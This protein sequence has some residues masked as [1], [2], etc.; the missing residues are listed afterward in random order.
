MTKADISRKLLKL[1]DLLETATDLSSIWA[2]FDRHLGLNE[3]FIDQCK[4]VQDKEMNLIYQAI[5]KEVFQGKTEWMT[6]TPMSFRYKEQH[7]VHGVC[8]MNEH[9]SSGFYFSDIC[10][11]MCVVSMGKQTIY[12]RFFLEKIGK[13]YNLKLLN[14]LPISLN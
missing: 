7:F 5:A 2:F 8:D 3:S 9:L 14:D 11:G 13:D 4:P 10:K 6:L 1:K 12:C